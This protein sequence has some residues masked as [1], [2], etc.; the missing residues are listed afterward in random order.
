[1]LIAAIILFVALALA[2]LL[3]TSRPRRAES[4]LH[5]LLKQ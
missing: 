1:M 5:R 3:L 4:R 2:A